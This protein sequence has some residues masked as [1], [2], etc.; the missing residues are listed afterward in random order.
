MG[1]LDTGTRKISKSPRLHCPLLRPLWALL[2][3][4]GSGNG[5][6]QTPSCF[7]DRTSRQSPPVQYGGGDGGT[8]QARMLFL[9]SVR[10]I[11]SIPISL[12]PNVTFSMRLLLTPWCYSAN[13]SPST[14]PFPYF[15]PALRTSALIHNVLCAKPTAPLEY[16]PHSRDLSLLVHSCTPSV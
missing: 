9:L 14:G 4:G 11:S 5:P 6:M 3:Q 2:R 8:L 1:A 13:P 10:L 12:N 7:S 15:S 16:Q